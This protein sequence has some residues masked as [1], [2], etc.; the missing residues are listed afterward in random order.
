[1]VLVC[2]YLSVLCADLSDLEHG[3]TLS[4]FEAEAMMDTSGVSLRRFHSRPW[5]RLTYWSFLYDLL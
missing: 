1:M 2:Q 3:V 4:A 5:V